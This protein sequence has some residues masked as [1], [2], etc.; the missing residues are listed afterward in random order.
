MGE[1]T[2]TGRYRIDRGNAA[3]ELAARFLESQGLLLLARNFRCR[4]GELDIIALDGPALVIAEIRQRANK[5]FGGA[6]ASVTAA[7]Q[8]KV[9]TATQVFL[10][11]AP[12]LRRF[13]VRFDVIAI[14]GLPEESPE[15]EWIRG[16]FAAT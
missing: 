3:E 12:R 14:H 13:A 5:D 1:E 9:I 16:A 15:I 2:R 11:R 8:H 10:Q 6:A 7:K 4:A